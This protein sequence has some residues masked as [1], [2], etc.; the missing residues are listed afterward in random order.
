[1]T[2]NGFSKV[3]ERKELSN[4]PVTTFSGTS[5]AITGTTFTFSNNVVKEYTD[6]SFPVGFTFNSGVN[7][8]L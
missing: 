5:T 7:Y 2:Q 1:M 4:L 8:F 3:W 6:L